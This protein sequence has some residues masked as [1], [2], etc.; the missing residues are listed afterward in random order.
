MKN[1]QEVRMKNKRN[2]NLEVL[3]S[4][5]VCSYFLFHKKSKATIS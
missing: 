3:N 2:L 5:F 1:K 4:L